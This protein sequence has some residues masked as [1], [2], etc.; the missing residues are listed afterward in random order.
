METKSNC[1]ASTKPEH[2]NKELLEELLDYLYGRRKT[3]E[4]SR[5]IYT[6]TAY[7]IFNIYFREICK[8]IE[9]SRQPDK[10]KLALRLQDENWE[11]FGGFTLTIIRLLVEA[12]TRDNPSF[13]I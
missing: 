6:N 5:K 1:Y 2:P 4:Y 10:W 3:N 13:V 7:Y 8:E 9:N 11:W 12:K